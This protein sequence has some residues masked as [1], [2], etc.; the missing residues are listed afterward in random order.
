[1]PGDKFNKIVDVANTFRK[2]LLNDKLN[3]K[4]TMK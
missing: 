1:M 4:Q 3:D 2:K